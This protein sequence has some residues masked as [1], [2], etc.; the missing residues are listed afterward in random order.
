VSTAAEIAAVVLGLAYLL[1]AIREQRSCWIFG[2]AA[3][4]LFLAVFWRAGLPMQALLQVYY[5]LIAVH[6]W[7]HWGKD[8]SA[9]QTP[10]KRSRP[11]VH[12]VSILALLTLSVATIAARDLWTDS[13]AWMD[14]LSSWGGVL[15]T[16][17]VARK[18]LEAWLY[19]IV[20]DTLTV[21]LYIDA[22]LLP[23]SAL[24]ALYTVLALIGWRQWRAS[25][26]QQTL[27]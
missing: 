20:I 9:S 6:G 5:V 24:Y 26:H 3:S 15:A 1:L 2:A 4:L 23:S 12:L 13:Q 21:V 7:L 27:N 8:N 18:I 25:Y 11:R 14:A 22:G 10:V 19:W 16:W 17:M